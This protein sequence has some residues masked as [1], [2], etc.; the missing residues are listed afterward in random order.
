MDAKVVIATRVSPELAARI[1]RLGPTSRV[2]RAALNRGV[3]SIERER[4]EA[5]VLAVV[6]RALKRTGGGVFIPDLRQAL[7]HLDART[8]DR[9]LVCLARRGEFGMKEGRREI[10]Q[11]AGGLQVQDKGL[12]F[13]I[14][15]RSMVKPRPVLAPTTSSIGPQRGTAGWPNCAGPW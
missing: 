13:W 14:V 12:M 15:R 1:K 3:A 6:Q 10:P 7:A 5:H 8:L 4:L 9:I 11:A 2:V